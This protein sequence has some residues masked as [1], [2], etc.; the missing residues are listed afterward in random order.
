MEILAFLLIGLIAGW[1]TG[2]IMVGHG[3]GVFLDIA[4]GIVGA[5]VGGFIFQILGVA[6]Y[7]F[8][9]QI[10]MSVVGASTLLLIVSLFHR[11]LKTRKI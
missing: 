7:S 6:V 1:I 9:G 10:L 11:P 8:W 4:L 3:L 5:L 2:H